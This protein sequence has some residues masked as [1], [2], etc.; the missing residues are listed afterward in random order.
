M[1]PAYFGSSALSSGNW[2]LIGWWLAA[3]AGAGCAAFALQSSPKLVLLRSAARPTT[4]G[5]TVL[6][7]GLAGIHMAT[8]A[9]MDAL[10]ILG[11]ETKYLAVY[12]PLTSVLEEVA[13]RGTLDSHV[14]HRG[15][16]RSRLSALFVSALWGLWHLPIS[17]GLPIPNHVLVLISWHRLSISVVSARGRD[18]RRWSPQTGDRRGPCRPLLGTRS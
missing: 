7:L 11:T 15:E 6:T 4:V 12:F 10:A 9:P 2:T 1:V 16:G 8:G 13:F 17:H 14:H 5:V 3:V 18:Q